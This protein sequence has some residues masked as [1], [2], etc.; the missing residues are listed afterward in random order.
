[1]TSNDVNEK[2]SGPNRTKI[3][4][5]D[6]I[7]VRYWSNQSDPNRTFEMKDNGMFS[8]CLIIRI[9]NGNDLRL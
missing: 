2:S 3:I 1:M 9:Q 7:V 8:R 5:G 4:E 6:L